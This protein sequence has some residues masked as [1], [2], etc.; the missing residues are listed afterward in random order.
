MLAQLTYSQTLHTVTHL[1]VLPPNTKILPK[2][3]P[4]RLFL[5]NR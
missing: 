3:L 5:H 4:A 1:L 2:D